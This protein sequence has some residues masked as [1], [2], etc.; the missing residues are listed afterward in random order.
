MPEMK[1]VYLT[2]RL[3]HT[4]SYNVFVS[5]LKIKVIID[6]LKNTSEKTKLEKVILKK[7]TNDY[8]VMKQK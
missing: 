8:L 3:Y 1:L 2:I 6:L 4:V 5:T 7:H